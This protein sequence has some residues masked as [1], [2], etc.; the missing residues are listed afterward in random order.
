MFYLCSPLLIQLQ[1]IL[2]LHA[3]E[4][5]WK[6]Q[7]SGHFQLDGFVY[8]RFKGFTLKFYF[9]KYL[10]RNVVIKSCLSAKRIDFAFVSELKQSRFELY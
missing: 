7:L 3:K 10:L 5:S 8:S 6:E 9:V 1:V 2:F 4:T